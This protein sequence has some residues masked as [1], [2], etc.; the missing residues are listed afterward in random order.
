[1]LPFEHALGALGALYVN[2]ENLR[3]SFRSICS[4]REWCGKVFTAAREVETRPFLKV[5][6]ERVDSGKQNARAASLDL[7]L[8]AV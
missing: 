1:M 5:P 3:T 6:L 8:L 4:T 2:C 7:P